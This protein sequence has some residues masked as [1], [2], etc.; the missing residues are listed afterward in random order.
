MKKGRDQLVRTRPSMR[1]GWFFSMLGGFVARSS[2]PWRAAPLPRP[3]RRSAR[4]RRG[5]GVVARPRPSQVPD[6]VLLVGPVLSVSSLA[7]DQVMHRLRSAKWPVTLR[8]SETT[9]R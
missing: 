3:T 7:H 5:D 8:F 1:R 9:H 2:T 4:A 6:S